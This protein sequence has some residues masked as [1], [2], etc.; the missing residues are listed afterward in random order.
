MLGIAVAVFSLGAGIA[1]SAGGAFPQR[2]NTFSWR[3]MAPTAALAHTCALDHQPDFQRVTIGPVQFESTLRAR[4][5]AGRMS[6]ISSRSSRLWDCHAVG[7][8]AHAALS[9]RK[10][11]ARCGRTRRLSPA[12]RVKWPPPAGRGRNVRFRHRAVTEFS[13][14]YYDG[15]TSART[16]VRVRARPQPLVG[17]ELNI[18]VR[19]PTCASTRVEDRLS[20][21]PGGAQLHTDDHA[22]LPRCSRAR[23]A[24]KPGC[25]NSNAAG[26]TRL[27][28]SY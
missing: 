1:A 8:G 26:V 7:G 9:R 23:T 25:T 15:R 28:R 14:V 27:R 2:R 21:L 20:S 24:S 17:A 12:K 16:P 4:D 19:S 13:A 6:S 10:Q 3:R 11:Y 5:L 18:E 22:A